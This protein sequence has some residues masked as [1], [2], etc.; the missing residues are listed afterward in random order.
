MAY[1]DLLKN[2][3][4]SVYDPKIDV[5]RT[6]EKFFHNDY[7]QCINGVRLNRTEYIHHVLAQ[8]ENIHIDVIDYR[9]RL[10]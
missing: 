8:K 2:I 4:D 9:S 5:T 10:Y 1:I 7:E 6:I 3:L